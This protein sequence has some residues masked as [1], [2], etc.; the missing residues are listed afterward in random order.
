VQIPP[1]RVRA[2]LVQLVDHNVG[3]TGAQEADQRAG[4]QHVTDHRFGPAGADLL[5]PLFGPGEHRH[6]MAVLEEPGHQRTPM[7]PVP[8]A[9]KTRM[10]RRY[11]R[12]AHSRG[13]AAAVNAPGHRD[14]E[15]LVELHAPKPLG[16]AVLRMVRQAACAS[17]SA[18]TMIDTRSPF[19]GHKGLEIHEPGHG[20]RQGQHPVG[21]RLVLG[22]NPRSQPR[23]EHRHDLLV[24]WVVGHPPIVAQLRDGRVP[25]R[26][27]ADRVP[28]GSEPA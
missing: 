13:E 15:G 22:S 8:P 28:P 24:R 19:V 5:R 12:G 4:R 20:G 1:R 17:A 26:I 2:R 6:V 7:A 16:L 21:H 25:E 10:L 18:K 9:T 27:R 11:R 23:P 3:V 14:I